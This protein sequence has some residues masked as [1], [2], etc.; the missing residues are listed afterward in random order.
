MSLQRQ[1]SNTAD[2]CGARPHGHVH[3][4][5]W[6]MTKLTKCGSFTN[7]SGADIAMVTWVDAAA[8]LRLPDGN[9]AAATLCDRVVPG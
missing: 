3:R 7:V 6:K 5:R 8:A 4:A 9:A 2:E 1:R